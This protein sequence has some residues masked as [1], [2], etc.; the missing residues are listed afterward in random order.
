[1]KDY[2]IKRIEKELGVELPEH[3]VKFLLHFSGLKNEEV[4]IENFLYSNPDQ[5]IEMNRMIGFYSNSKIIKKKLIIGD[6]GGGGFYLIDLVNPND[7][8]VYVFDHE[9]SVEN[10]FDEKTETWNWGGLEHHETLESYKN[11]LEAMFGRA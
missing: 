10:Y 5:S 11:T 4:D 9:E 1:M 2:E 3:Y 7:K 6:N 8:K